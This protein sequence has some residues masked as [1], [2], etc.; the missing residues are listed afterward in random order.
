MATETSC[1]LEILRAF[2]ELERD[3]G[4]ESF[5]PQEVLD[6][7]RASNSPYKSSTIR[8]HIISRMCAEAPKNHGSTFADLSRVARGTYRRIV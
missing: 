6:H 8:T 1:R 3:T 5:T 2:Q 4:R 7:L